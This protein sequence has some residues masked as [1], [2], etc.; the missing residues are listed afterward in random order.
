MRIKE[1][2]KGRGG[3]GK[4]GKKSARILTGAVKVKKWH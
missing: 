1:S 4:A 3:G 2:R